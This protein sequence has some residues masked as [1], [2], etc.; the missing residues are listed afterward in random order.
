MGLVRP[1]LMAR[2]MPVSR[3]GT[4]LAVW[5]AHSLSL[6]MLLLKEEGRCE[7]NDEAVSLACCVI[8][9]ECSQK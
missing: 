7:H 1:D 3:A 5:A 9:P 2:A 6:N 8:Q 4:N